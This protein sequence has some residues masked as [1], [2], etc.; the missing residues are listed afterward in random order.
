MLNSRFA[1]FCASLFM[2]AVVMPTSAA[3]F[4]VGRLD[5]TPVW[6]LQHRLVED[7]IADRRPDTLLLL[8][9]EPVFTVG[10]RGKAEHWAGLEE[11]GHQV[12]HVERGGSVTYHG[13]GQLVGYPIVRLTDHC[14][15]PKA[16]VRL[17]E[18]VVIR[19]LAD[20]GIAGERVE[21]RPGVWVGGSALE[22][23]AAMGVRINR[24]VT[25]HGFAL[26]VD[27][28]LAPFSRITPCGI[29]D[30]P[31]TSMAAKLGGPVDMSLVR[32]QIAGHFGR[33]FDLDWT[34][35]EPAEALLPAGVGS[36]GGG[37]G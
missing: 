37:R 15:G 32:R 34:E 3:L 5:Y 17:L 9:H 30:C 24:G 2:G 29:A 19:T 4:N 10:R 8:E 11:E 22:K 36:G 12:H 35:Q 26:N 14:P 25:M 16:Y 28:D 1:L 31:V 23:I 13:P 7:R 18:E 33:L 20:W 6:D 27:L 21:Q